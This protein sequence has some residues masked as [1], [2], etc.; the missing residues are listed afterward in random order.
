MIFTDNVHNAFYERRKS[1]NR[2][3]TVSKSTKKVAEQWMQL[4]VGK[5]F[6][7]EED[8][9]GRAP[10]GR[11]VKAWRS[12]DR[13]FPGDIFQREDGT[14]G[15]DDG[16]HNQVNGLKTLDAAKKVLL[17]ASE[18][19][20]SLKRKFLEAEEEARKAREEEA[21][22]RPRRWWDSDNRKA[23]V[24]KPTKKVAEQWMQ[25]TPGYDYLDDIEGANGRI[26]KS[27]APTDGTIEGMVYQLED[28]TYGF[29]NVNGIFKDGF[30]TLDEAK[31]ALLKAWGRKPVS[32]HANRMSSVDMKA[33]RKVALAA[34]KP[35]FELI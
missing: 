19:R 15:Y 23:T 21:R 26:V 30:K 32:S 25:L 7:D 3:A 28:G 27:W 35:G 12:T 10:H 16:F 20:R 17:G 24:S 13:N 8:D 31:N 33:A 29:N 18:T 11:V 5:Y 22:Q 34:V 14:Y 9:Y 4:K 6:Y 2:K 1:D